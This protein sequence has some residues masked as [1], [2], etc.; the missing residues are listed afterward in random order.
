MAAPSHCCIYTCYST[1]SFIIYVSLQLRYW[2]FF[3]I[4]I[5]LCKIWSTYRIHFYTAYWHDGT[6]TC[7]QVYR[8]RL[9]I[10]KMLLKANVVF[11]LIWFFRAWIDASRFLVALFVPCTLLCNCV[12]PL[13]DASPQRVA[14]QSPCN[15]GKWQLDENEQC[16]E[17]RGS[18]NAVIVHVVSEACPRK[19]AWSHYY[20]QLIPCPLYLRPW[21]S[22]TIW[23]CML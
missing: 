19:L 3:Y 13:T 1:P 22:A 8:N 10:L 9:G 5:C 14:K 12:G 17:H 18:D 21:K 6:V 4:C 23:R 15:S 7:E 16:D 2:L 20:N 11:G